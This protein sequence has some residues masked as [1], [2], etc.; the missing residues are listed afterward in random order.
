[1]H[2]I[3]APT[4]FQRKINDRFDTQARYWRDLYDEQSLFGVIHQE[5]RAISLGWIDA[6]TLPEESRILDIG[7]GTGLLAVDL[8]QRGHLVTAV[9]PSQAM[10]DLATAHVAE[11]G[12]DDRVTV[13]LGDAHTLSFAPNSYDLVVAL[14]VLPYLHTP[15][16]ALTE[17]GRVLKP[18]GYF[19]L[20]SNNP[21]RLNHVLDP[22]FTPMLAPLK[23]SVRRFFAV[24]TTSQ[25]PVRTFAIGTLRHLLTDAG[26]TI[27]SVSTLG[28]GPFTLAGRRLM[29]EAA[30]IRL[31]RRL[32]A[33][34]DREMPI[35]RATGTQHVV[36]A[37]RQGGVTPAET[38]SARSLVRSIDTMES[39]P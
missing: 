8:A 10:I 37:Q 14:G 11:I 4:V 24:G 20:S 13:T 18:G 16:L 28:F 2:T 36:V 38:D 34:A 3:P 21:W 39:T 9:D 5:R 19:L 32:Q 31:H 30:S 27:I 29:T 6:L 7:C 12:M 23:Q 1:M 33:L 26:F 22:R 35:L 15:A 25:P 17:I